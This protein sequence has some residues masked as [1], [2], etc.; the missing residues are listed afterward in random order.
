VELVE[1]KAAA[2]TAAFH[3]QDWPNQAGA[4]DLGG[5]RILDLIPLPG[6][7]EAAIALYDRKTGLM[8]TGDS[9]YP[10]RLY[11]A[12]WKMFVASIDRLV[13]FTATHPV[14]HLLGCH[15]EQ[16]ST[17]FLDY[18]VGSMYQPREHVLELG[19][20]ELLELQE[21]LKK[22]SGVPARV[23]LRDLTVW[24][25]NAEV[26]REMGR[27]QA[28]TEAAQRKLQWAQPH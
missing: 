21:A 23:A 15:I 19:R 20:G 25:M 22:Q 10:G 13:Q 5:G 11:I 28:E 7:H 16:S 3:L 8:L 18:P 6:H 14:T 12:D 24:P 2:L 26:R 27:V 17:P 1:G 4:I 9:F